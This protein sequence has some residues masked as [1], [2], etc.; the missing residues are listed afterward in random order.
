M[1]F[2]LAYCSRLL[3]GALQASLACTV[4]AG[5]A[6]FTPSLDFRNVVAHDSPGFALINKIEYGDHARRIEKYIHDLR[7][8]FQE[9]RASPYDVDVDSNT[10]LHVSKSALPLGNKMS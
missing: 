1:R 7:Q 5:G 10:L 2:R 3:A 8:L 9:R 4:G 6:S